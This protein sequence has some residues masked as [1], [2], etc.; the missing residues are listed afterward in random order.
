VQQLVGLQHN[1][2]SAGQG[3]V[4]LGQLLWDF[5]TQPTPLSRV[6]TLQIVYPQGRTPRV[7]VREPDLVALAGGRRLPHVY[8]QKPPHL[9]LYLPGTGE[10]DNSM[11]ISVTIV[12]WAI[13]WLFYFE[14]WLES[15]DWKGGGIHPK[16]HVNGG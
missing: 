9:C 8:E 14:E 10:W 7:V 4:R 13:L 2:I 6:Y 5:E 15:D 16:V 11:R 1:P 12:P 3:R